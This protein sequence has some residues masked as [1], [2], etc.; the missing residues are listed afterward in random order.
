MR[1]AGHALAEAAAGRL[2]PGIGRVYPLEQAAEA[3]TA[4]EERSLLGKVLLSAR[5][6]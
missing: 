3:H 5:E 6:E 1:L 2:R 4:I